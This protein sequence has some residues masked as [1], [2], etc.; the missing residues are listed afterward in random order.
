MHHPPT[1]P[2]TK[3]W[4]I[5]VRV[6]HWALVSCVIVDYFL[7]TDGGDWHRWLG[8]A[9]CALVAWRVVW[10]FVGSEHA[11]FTDFFPT[12]S[13][14]TR[15]VQDLA[16]GRQVVHAGHNPL[17]ALMMLTLLALVAALGVTGW[18]MSLDRFWGKD[19]LEDV[20]ALLAH[21]IIASAAV[22]AAA[23]VVMG[24]LE[25][26]RLIKAMITGVKERW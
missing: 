22:H 8:Y 2:C 25:R 18:M 23:A 4:D 26:T 3:V 12:P 21:A 24:R 10:G 6:F 7:V 15:H 11:R 1:L 14:V 17:G 13:R 19:W 5:P 16:S 20:H 9:A